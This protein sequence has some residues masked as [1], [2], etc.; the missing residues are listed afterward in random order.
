[1]TFDCTGRRH[2]LESMKTILFIDDEL[3][4]RIE[5]FM[6]TKDVTFNVAVNLLL[7]QG[8]A[9]VAGACVKGEYSGP[10]FDSKLRSGIDP[11]GMNQLA[12]ELE[13]EEHIA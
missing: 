11:S 10:V 6:A 2:T 9:A 7:R 1:M 3:S 5:R 4:E 12:G 13:S 8:L